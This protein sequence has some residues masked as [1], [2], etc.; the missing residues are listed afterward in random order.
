MMV[1]APMEEDRRAESRTEAHTSINRSDED[2][3]VAGYCWAACGEPGR[4]TDTEPR[5]AARICAHETGTSRTI[6]TAIGQRLRI[7]QIIAPLDFLLSNWR[8]GTRQQ[9]G[10]RIVQLTLTR[11]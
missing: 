5:L 8:H 2:S 10:L 3:T 6:R 4:P 11:L 7:R 9:G 1:E